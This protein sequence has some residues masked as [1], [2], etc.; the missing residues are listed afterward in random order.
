[1]TTD[2]S[3]LILL[4]NSEGGHIRGTCVKRGVSAQ[5]HLFHK[6]DCEDHS[7][8]ACVVSTANAS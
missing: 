5:M 4:L 3:L 6:E 2:F 7:T 8:S 1:M